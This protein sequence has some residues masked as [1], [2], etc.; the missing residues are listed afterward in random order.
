MFCLLKVQREVYLPGPETWVHLWDVNEKNYT[1]PGTVT[2][3]SPLG[4]VPVF[5]RASSDWISLFR[6]I[7]D[8]Y[9][10]PVEVA[11]PTTDAPSIASMIH[12]NSKMYSFL[13]FTVLICKLCQ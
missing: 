3:D 1:G 11:D 12:L 7:R 4:Q 13:L 10:L 8:T 6:A 9:I 5:F 2:I